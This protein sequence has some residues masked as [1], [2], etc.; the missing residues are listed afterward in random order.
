MLADFLRARVDGLFKARSADRDAE[1]DNSRTELVLR[2][3]EEALK[4]AELEHSGLNT[5]V[6]D[7]LARGAISLGNGT[8]DYL[9]RESAD[10]IVQNQFDWQIASGQRRLERLSHQIQ[11]FMS[12]KAALMSRFPDF[13]PR[14]DKHHSA[15][16]AQR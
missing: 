14:Y 4:R 6:Q 7:I 11:A 8:D 10:T 5:R 2:S 9:T 16:S 15:R 13:K 12:L 1:A 3:I